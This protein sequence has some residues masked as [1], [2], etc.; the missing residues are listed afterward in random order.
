MI[1]AGGHSAFEVARTPRPTSS[2]AGAPSATAA[3]TASLRRATSRRD[4]TGYED[5]DQHGTWRTLPEYGAVWV[6]DARRAGLGAVSPRSLGVDLAV[7]LDVGRRRAVGLR[8]F[9]LRPLGARPRPLGVGARARSCAARCT[10]RRSS[11]SSAARASPFAVRSG[12]AVGWFP[13]GWREPYRPW[14]RA[15]PAHVRNVNV[16]HVTN[17]TN[18]TNVTHVH[19]NRPDAVTVVPQQSF[20]SREAGGHG[21]ASTSRKRISRG[22][23]SYATGRPREPV[24]ASIA[25][26]RA[27]PAPAGAGRRARSRRGHAAARGRA[28]ELPGARDRARRLA[29]QRQRAASARDRARGFGARRAERRGRGTRAERAAPRLPQQRRAAA[30]AVVAAAA[31][32]AAPAAA[33]TAPAPALHRRRA[34]AAPLAAQRAPLRLR[35]ARRSTRATSGCAGAERAPRVRT[36][37]RAPQRAPR[38]TRERPPC[39]AA[40]AARAAPSAAATPGSNRAPI[41]HAQLA[42]QAQRREARA[43]PGAPQ[44]QPRSERPRLACSRASMQ[45][46]PRP[47]GRSTPQRSSRAGPRHGPRAER[48]PAAARRQLTP[49]AAPPLPQSSPAGGS[50]VSGVAA[51]LPFGTASDGSVHDV[52][53]V[54][55]AL[56]GGDPGSADPDRADGRHRHRR[57]ARHRAQIAERPPR[58]T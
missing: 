43:A 54:L 42:G 32:A 5:L 51:K 15:S 7:G 38:S 25:P 45:P 52:R 20:V 58:P 56:R 2:T 6:P 13:L 55:E 1:A 35:T 17:V 50:V 21:H 26:E 3:K 41:A 28:R 11:L 29:R 10:R 44:A 34:A 27:G 47:A 31:P 48:A 30:A 9:P 39:S 8:A 14:Y 57:R 4:M 18:I 37:R 40:T 19:R 33:A 53:G 12:P 24:R 16:T 23:R 36:G 46:A 49:G 22:P